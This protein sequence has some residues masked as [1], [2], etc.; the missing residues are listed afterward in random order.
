MKVLSAPKGM[1][2]CFEQLDQL[3][4]LNLSGCDIPSAHVIKGLAANKGV[5]KNL[6]ELNLNTLGISSPEFILQ[7]LP[8]L[9]VLTCL[10]LRNGH[11]GITDDILQG[12]IEHCRNLEVL[13]LSNCSQLTDYGLTG[14]HDWQAGAMPM[15]HNEM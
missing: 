1:Q 2:D 11:E 4:S 12:I 6:K 9:Q 10:E 7:L 13:V 8:N 5:V 15:P 3:T 14:R